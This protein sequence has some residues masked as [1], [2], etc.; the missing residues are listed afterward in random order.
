MVVL[1]PRS[2]PRIAYHTDAPASLS[3]PVRKTW[4][5]GTVTSA[6]KRL[7]PFIQHSLNVYCTTYMV[8]GCDPAFPDLTVMHTKVVFPNGFLPCL[9]QLFLS[10]LGGS[11]L[12]RVKS[13]SLQTWHRHG[14]PQ[15]RR[16]AFA[17]APR[18]AYKAPA[19]HLCG[20]CPL[21]L[22]SF[23]FPHVTTCL[24]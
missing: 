6:Q 21:R 23:C 24:E 2:F 3:C 14:R 1:P 13:K 19:T 17:A 7:Y 11:R 5:L 18:L 15:P 8:S 12:E 16:A 9:H 4:K 10:F 22:C 20:F